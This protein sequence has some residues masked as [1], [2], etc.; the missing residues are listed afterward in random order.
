[1]Y[2]KRISF[3]LR[4]NTRNIITRSLL[5]RYICFKSDA[6]LIPWHNTIVR[7]HTRDNTPYTLLFSL[8]NRNW[9]GYWNHSHAPD[10]SY[11]GQLASDFFTPCLHKE[12]G[13]LFHLIT[14]IFGLLVN[15][16]PC[17]DIV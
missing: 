1:M 4:V 2:Q 7:H 6:L 11:P 8:F 9:A 14:P 17:E 3:L 5:M 15:R 12:G 10:Q 16:L 13:S